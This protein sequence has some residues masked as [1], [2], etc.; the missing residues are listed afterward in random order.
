MIRI[1]LNEHRECVN[2]AMA[3][4]KAAEEA[5]RFASGAKRGQ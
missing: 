4:F 5:I 1:P 2:K 3:L